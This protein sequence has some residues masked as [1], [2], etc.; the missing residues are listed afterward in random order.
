MHAKNKDVLFGL[1]FGK[2]AKI[3]HFIPL[4]PISTDLEGILKIT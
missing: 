1:S 3:T 2:I 4:R